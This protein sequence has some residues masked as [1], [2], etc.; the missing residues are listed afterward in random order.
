MKALFRYRR[1]SLAFCCR[2]AVP[3]CSPAATPEVP[4]TN[5]EK[6]NNPGRQ[7]ERDEG[8]SCSSLVESTQAQEKMI[9]DA[10]VPSLYQL[11]LLLVGEL[12]LE[13]V[14]KFRASSAASSFALFR[15][16][17]SYQNR[18]DMVRP[19]TVTRLDQAVR[20]P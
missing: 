15:F 9:M 7:E 4:R 14:K 13:P 16:L 5:A 11:P 6:P 12:G 18:A 2:E 20:P 10:V 3:F 19:W 17:P 8:K 1:R